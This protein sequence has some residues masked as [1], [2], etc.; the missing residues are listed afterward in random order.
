MSVLDQARAV[1]LAQPLCND[2]LGRQFAKLGHG[3]SNAKRGQAL[4]VAVCLEDNVDISCEPNPCPLCLSY[5]SQ[6]HPKARQAVSLLEDWEFE[7]YLMGTRVPEFLNEAEARLRQTLALTHG[8]PLKQSYNREVGKA[9]GALLGE[10]GRQ[11]EV[12]FEH[13]EVLVTVDLI[14]DKVSVHVNPLYVFGRYRKL[15]RGIPQTHWPCGRCKGKGCDACNHSGA[16][17]PQSVESLI[18]APL[19]ALCEG[20]THVLHG[21]GREDIDARMLGRG[22]PFVLEIKQPRRRFLD[23]DQVSIQI[24]QAA[25]GKVQVRDLQPVYGNVVGAIK[26]KNAQKCYRMRI[27]LDDAVD[28][29]SFHSA[30]QSLVGTIE[31]RTPQRVAHRRADRVRKRQLMEIEGQLLD[32]NSAQVALRGAGG[33]YVKELISG[34]GGRTTPSL[35][36]ALGVACRVTELD[37]TDILG[38]FL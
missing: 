25:Q 6:I 28:E 9:F 2:C 14:W 35:A 5:F 23:W 31:Q 10:R 15:L 8:E 37:V 38:D 16:Q 22:R 7:R 24:N 11:V 12:D 4:R 26:E 32:A 21:A 27:A 34:D 30:L 17:Y 33:L 1:L 20:Q 19:Q 29:T 18:G 3:L 36:A 13:P